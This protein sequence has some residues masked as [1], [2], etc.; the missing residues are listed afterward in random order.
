MRSAELEVTNGGLKMLLIPTTLLQAF[1][2][3][4]TI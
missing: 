1:R 3:R 4:F 2:I